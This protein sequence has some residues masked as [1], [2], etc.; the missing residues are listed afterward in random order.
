MDRW[1]MPMLPWV[2]AGA[3]RRHAGGDHVGA[4]YLVAYGQSS[5]ANSCLNVVTVMTVLQ[6]ACEGMRSRGTT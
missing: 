4:R 3:A 5:G 2:R 6:D 1:Q